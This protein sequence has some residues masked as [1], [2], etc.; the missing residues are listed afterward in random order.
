MHV[1]DQRVIITGATGGVGPVMVEAFLALGAVVV[2]VGRRRTALADLMASCEQHPNLSVAEC[3][4]TDPNG[5][6]KLLKS[7][8]DDGGVDS[9]VHVA[10][11]F[12]YGSL[13]ELSTQAADRL[14]DINLRT[15]TYLLQASLP[16]M[17]ERGRGSIV[18]FSSERA[19]EPA[20]GFGVYGAAKAAVLYLARTA[21]IENAGS[22]VRINSIL[23]GV[24]DTAANRASMP[25]ADPTG[26]VKPS[27]IASAAVWLCSAGAQATNGASLRLPN[28]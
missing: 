14:I 18:L 4:L 26:W 15:T 6:K 8:H 13:H 19:T 20:A 11:G 22:G 1:R 21:A 23:P 17:R 3:D 7:V 28:H 12:E 9:I 24:I 16:L 10:G 5:V 27:D 2:G 25:D